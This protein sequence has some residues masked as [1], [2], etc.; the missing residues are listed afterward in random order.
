M[1]NE[2]AYLLQLQVWFRM[3]R[4][5]HTFVNCTGKITTHAI[6]ELQKWMNEGRF[7]R[8]RLMGEVNNLA[9]EATKIEAQIDKFSSRRK[10][11]QEHNELSLVNRKPSEQYA[12]ELIDQLRRCRF[13]MQ[14]RID[15]MQDEVNRFNKKCKEVEKA[16]LNRRLDEVS[17]LVK[18]F[19]DGP[20][21]YE[22]F[23]K[24]WQVWIELKC[25]E[26]KIR[27]R[28]ELTTLLNV[29]IE[30][31]DTLRRRY[32][33]TIDTYEKYDQLVQASSSSERSNECVT[34]D[35]LADMRSNLLKDDTHEKTTI[36]NWI[37]KFTTARNSYLSDRTFTKEEL[38]R[39]AM[40]MSTCPI[41][42]GEI[43]SQ[44]REQ[45]AIY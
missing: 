19:V 40:S 37:N 29:A 15:D 28:S 8:N 21:C 44:I 38:E 34:I 41:R 42:N 23:P 3:A 11:V 25:V 45:R 1:Q 31:E 13:D 36:S 20:I 22:Q 4:K 32:I 30:H 27:S 14:F 2:T 7:P 5:A 39:L 43:E 18:F 26:G 24:L 6:K 35:K 33:A 9:N 16:L 10:K 12:L 17:Q